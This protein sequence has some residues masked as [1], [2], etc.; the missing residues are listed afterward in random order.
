[1]DCIL[2]DDV[3]ARHVEAMIKN[4]LWMAFLAKKKTD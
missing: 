2:K 1:M 3:L 4:V